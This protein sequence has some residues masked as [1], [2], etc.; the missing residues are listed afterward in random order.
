MTR[1][2]EYYVIC[3]ESLVFKTGK[4]YITQEPDYYAN[5]IKDARL[6]PS[7][8]V[9]EEEAMKLREENLADRYWIEKVDEQGNILEVF[10]K[11]KVYLVGYFEDYKSICEV[12]NGIELVP[13]NKLVGYVK[14]MI[15]EECINPETIE[16]GGY[17]IENMNV[18]MAIKI[19]ENDGYTIKEYNLEN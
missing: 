16:D 18:P 9:A 12:L 8:E 2:K 6:F 10:D 1:K 15:D 7:K 11:R 3:S 19:L 17:D 4:G 13:D 5:C 14:K